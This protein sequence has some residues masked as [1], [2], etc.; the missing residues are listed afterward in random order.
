V[1]LRTALWAIVHDGKAST[2][3]QDRRT[4]EATWSFG[5]SE[6]IGADTKQRAADALLYTPKKKAER[7]DVV[8]ALE[9]VAAVITQFRVPLA[10]ST[11]RSAQPASRR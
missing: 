3:E 5:L 7:T 1:K 9:A 8:L 2:A 4:F 11:R 6:E 10:I